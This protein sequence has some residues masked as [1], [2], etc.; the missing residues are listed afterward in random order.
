MMITPVLKDFIEAERL[1]GSS[2]LN[3]Y[4]IEYHKRTSWPFATYILI[5]IAVSLSTK[6]NRGG[7]GLNMAI[8]IFIC[9]IYVFLMQISSTF[10]SVGQISPFIAVWFPNI[11]F[12]VLGIWLYIRAP[13]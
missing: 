5:L 13:K 6:K 10:G 2:K 9:L 8:G 3:T 7:L 4:Y 12:L 1:R 11:I